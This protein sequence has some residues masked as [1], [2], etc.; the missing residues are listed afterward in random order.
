MSLQLN[1]SLFLFKS[2]FIQEI[3]IRFGID[4][5]DIH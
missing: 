1:S 3:L 2:N 5:V 4:K